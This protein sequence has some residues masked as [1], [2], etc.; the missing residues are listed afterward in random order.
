MVYAGVLVFIRQAKQ[1]FI[2][3]S[4]LVGRIR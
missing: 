3:H 4:W 1:E 2:M